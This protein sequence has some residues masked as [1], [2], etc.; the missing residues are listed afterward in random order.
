[1]EF[2]K[3]APGILWKYTKQIL[4]KINIVDIVQEY[5]IYLEELA[6]EN[7]THRAY[8]PFHEGKNGGR[9]RTPSFFVSKTTNSFN[10]FG[11]GKYG[12]LVSF[13]SLIEGTPPII[14]LEKLA[15]KVGFI[16]K[17]GKFDDLN[18]DTDIQYD[19]SKS[20]SPILVEIGVIIRKHMRQNINQTEKIC[21][22]LDQYINQLEHDDYD[23]AVKLRDKLV[24]KLGAAAVL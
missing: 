5:D 14:A 2:L 15:K 11:C 24:E 20:I 16:D 3:P 9:E 12:N 7:F 10:C 19:P 8:C 23:R 17:N 18:I 22:K 4:S 1:M 13:V 21:K 6:S